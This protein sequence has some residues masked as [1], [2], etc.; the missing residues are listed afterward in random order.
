MFNMI[1]QEDDKGKSLLG[2][3]DFNNGEFILDMFRVVGRKV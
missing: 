3:F 1:L 2:T